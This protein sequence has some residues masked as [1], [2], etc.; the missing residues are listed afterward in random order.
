MDKDKAKVIVDKVI[1]QV[2]GF[3]N[4]LT[5]DQIMSKFAFDIKLPQQVYDATT[6]EPTWVMSTS[7]TKFVSLKNIQKRNG[8]DDWVIPKRPLKNLQDVLAAWQETNMM[9]AERYSESEHVAESD[10]VTMSQYV[11]R[12]QDIHES[13]N[14]VFCDGLIK[15]EYTVASQRSNS[16]NFCIRTE[17]SKICSNSFSVNWSG[18]IADSFFIQDSYDLNNC[19]FCSHMVSKKYCIANMQFEKDEY[20]RLR[21]QVIEWILTS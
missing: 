11:F 7:P 4:P 17:D 13:K 18:K 3:Q 21:K 20:M 15:S 9:A 8:I 14:I 19:M 10:N 12:S 16:L 5:L 2:F 6:N 1:G